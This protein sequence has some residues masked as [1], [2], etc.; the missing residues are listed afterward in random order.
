MGAHSEL[1]QMAVVAEAEELFNRARR[2]IDEAPEW[3]TARHAR[4]LI[5]RVVQR[6]DDLRLRLEA[7]LVVA[8]FGGTGTGKSSLVNALVGRDVTATGR[9]R[10]TTTIPVLLLH[11]TTDP[12]AL[13]LDADRFHI[14]TVDSPLLRDVVLIDCPDPD[15]SETAESGTNLALLRSIVPHCDVLIY[16][17][18]QQKYRNA[19]VIDELADVASGCRL[20]F[21]Q[22]HADVDSDIR[23]DWKS[24]LAQRYDVPE[25]FFVDS[26]RAIQQQQEGIR[27]S[28]DFGRLQ[29]LLTNQLGTSRRTA[30]RRA[31]VVDLLEEALTL[32]AEEY[33]TALPA[34]KQLQ[35]ALESQRD[36]VGDELTRQLCD[37]LLRNRS[38]WERRLVSAVTDVWGFSPFA[39]VLRLYNGIGTLVASFSFFRARSS[40]QMALI[41]A[42]QGARWLQARAREQE[43]DSSLD[44]L[45]S[46]GI[47]DAQLQETRMVISGYVRAAGLQPSRDAERADLTALR[48]QAASVEREFLGDA[49]RGVDRLIDELAVAHTGWLTRCWYEALWIAYLVFVIGRVGHNFFWSSFL[50][51]IVDSGQEAE[52]LLTVDFYIPA[53]IFL[54]VW[55]G[56]LVLGFVWRLRRGLTS[57]I[58][59]LARTMA[60]Q[61]L[62]Q[63]LFPHLESICSAIVEDQRQLHALRERAGRF[64]RDL[65]RSTSFLGSRSH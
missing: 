49:K 60:E 54:L 58:R 1:E 45:S 18:T 47:S 44:R 9:Q 19:R 52:P 22:T 10:P 17:S 59:E 4:S 6:V 20:V 51:P 30:I 31:N 23:E 61:K 39:T 38:L 12:A 13:G 43:A 35:E 26:R 50:R 46:F 36:A 7:P 42:M 2:W 37:E 57:R 5:S 55:S 8:T 11:P 21:V 15:T 53:V 63:G 62:T 14:R 34:V 16:T 40:A 65:A 28:G 48:Q 33:E 64:R 27:P 29:E 3:E 24:H 56:L 41:G 32:S 25:M